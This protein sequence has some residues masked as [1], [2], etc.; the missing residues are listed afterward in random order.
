M[1]DNITYD[2]AIPDGELASVWTLVESEWL[3]AGALLTT[4][5]SAGIRRQAVWIDSV[6]GAERL[7]VSFEAASRTA[8]ERLLEASSGGLDAWIAARLDGGARP[9]ADARGIVARR[10]VLEWIAA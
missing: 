10:P 6:P 8:V 9:D 1:Q 7:V 2:I 4:L 3:D 5:S